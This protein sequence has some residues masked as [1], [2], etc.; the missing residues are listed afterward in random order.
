MSLDHW[1][2]AQGRPQPFGK[3]SLKES[4]IVSDVAPEDRPYRQEI[5]EATGN[6]GA[7]MDRWYRQAVVVIWPRDRYFRIL[8]GEGP[9]HAVGA[10]E[11]LIAETKKPAADADCRAFAKAIIERWNATG[12]TFRSGRS[13]DEISLATRMLKLLD[14]LGSAEL[15]VRFVRDILPDHCTGSE[16]PALVRMVQRL[17]WA[18]FADPLRRFSPGRLPTSTTGSWPRRWR[19]LKP[20]VAVPRR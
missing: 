17:G 13:E 9:D 2:D 6:E 11:Q 4:E 7:S 10:L 15:A 19:C 18:D 1:L 16:G 5:H 14:Q 20:C 12:R 8:A 3:L